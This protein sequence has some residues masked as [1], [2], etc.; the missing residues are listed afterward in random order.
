MQKYRVWCVF[1]VWLLVACGFAG[2][3]H[4]GEEGMDPYAA[5]WPRIDGSTAT[6]PLSEAL[7][8]YYTGI[9][10][11]AAA[12]TMQHHTTPNAYENLIEKRVDL[13]FVTAPAEEDLKMAE[14]HGVTLEVIP[15]VRDALVFLCNV[16]NPVT[17]VTMQQLRSIYTGEITN[18][19]DVGGEDAQI[20]AYQRT[21]RSGSQTLFL[22]ML[23]QGVE[24]MQAP[25]NLQPAWM[26]GLVDA[27][28]G[29]KNGRAAIGYTMYYY[30]TD[31]YGNDKIRLLAVDGVAP[32]AESIA[33]GRYPLCTHYYAVM[34]K[35]TLADS[36]ARALVSWLL[37]EEGQRL[38]SQAGYVPLYLL[39]KEE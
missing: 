3:A 25:T 11:Q 9:D 2:G 30:I 8:M 14:E 39:P 12:E 31:M 38:A 20:D 6:I 13:I 7:V 29:Y 23:M 22:Q 26:G 1:T 36:P 21:L 5:L 18:W 24:P 16:Q 34:R 32:D 10:A 15:V 17:G 37:T 27:V 28:A 4:A 19:R 33:T 35:D